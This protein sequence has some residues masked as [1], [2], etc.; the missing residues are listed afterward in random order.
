LSDEAQTQA[1]QDPGTP[2]PEV[3]APTPNV[4]EQPA[5]AAPS[6]PVANTTPASPWSKDLDF[7][8][9]EATRQSV[10]SYLREKVQPYVTDLEQKSAEARRLY[11]AFD[12]N[13]DATFEQVA[14]EFYG[15]E[16]AKAISDYVQAIESA[17][18]EGAQPQPDAGQLPPEVQ[19]LIDWRREQKDKAAF[20]AEFT[21][22]KTIPGNENIDKE[23]FIPFAAQ[24]ST[25]EEAAAKYRDWE[26][27]WGPRTPAPGTETATADASAQPGTQAPATLGQQGVE[28]GSPTPT[29]KHYDSYHD[30]I[31]DFFAEEAQ[32][33]QQLA[34]PVVG[35]AS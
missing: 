15:P 23:L 5:T 1:V 25:F 27:K 35:G 18:D 24:S 32:K 6:P 4:E 2:A 9:D 19:E 31:D 11:D 14:K 7:I 22:I 17:E 16:A 29:E 10:D 34:P 3:A 8:E 28:G 33:G 13:P 30:A 26:S 21:R 20:D 12:A